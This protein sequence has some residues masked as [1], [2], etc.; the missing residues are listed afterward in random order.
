MSREIGIIMAAGLGTRMRPLTER[1]PKPLVRVHGTP[2]IETVI[3][4]LKRRDISEIY[5]V[6]GYLKDR[7]SYLCEKYPEIRLLE[8]PDYLVKNNISS[9]YAAREALGTADC[10]IC[11]ADLLISDLSVFDRTPECSGYYGKR[12]AGYSAD[13]VFELQ[14]GFISRVGKG[15]TDTYNM[16][17]ISFFRQEDARLLAEKIVQAYGREENANL[18]WDEVVDQNLDTL[19]LRVFPVEEGQIIEID[20]ME[21]LTAIDA[22]AIDATAIDAMLRQ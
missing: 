15:G 7:F 21:E 16:V 5:V 9:I 3:K 17:G 13:W 2:L 11:E 12:V 6:V 19:R 1:V 22:A 18:Y 4:G 8:N 20:T 14:N 10:F